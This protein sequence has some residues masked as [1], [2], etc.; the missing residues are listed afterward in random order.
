LVII[1]NEIKCHVNPFLGLVGDAS[2]TLSPVSAP[3]LTSDKPWDVQSGL[4]MILSQIFSIAM[5]MILS[6]IFSIA[7]FK[8]YVQR[9]F[10][11]DLCFLFKKGEFKRFVYF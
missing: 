3:G 4:E 8:F 2:P 7:M 11:C 9:L 5:F 1:F 6:Q 10:R